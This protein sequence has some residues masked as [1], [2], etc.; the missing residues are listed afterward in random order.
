VFNCGLSFDTQCY[1][2][3]WRK[4]GS[5]SGGVSFDQQLYQAA[6]IAE[7]LAVQGRGSC[8]TNCCTAA[9]GG[10][11]CTSPDPNNATGGANIN[12]ECWA[13]QLGYGSTAGDPSS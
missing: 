4:A 1:L 13:T 12:L 6:E 11:T 2:P 9:D 5:V 8:L 3:G 7:F 10:R